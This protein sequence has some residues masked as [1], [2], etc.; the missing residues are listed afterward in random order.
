MRTNVYRAIVKLLIRGLRRLEDYSVPSASQPV[1][2]PD[3]GTVV[4]VLTNGIA[5]AFQRTGDD[6]L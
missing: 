2:E 4:P 1:C 6:P 3:S 5:N